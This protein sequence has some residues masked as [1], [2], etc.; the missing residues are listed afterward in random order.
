MHVAHALEHYKFDLSQGDK[1]L[2]GDLILTVHDLSGDESCF[3]VESTGDSDCEVNS[4]LAQVV[5]D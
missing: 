5:C 1:L 4:P 3:L 2:I